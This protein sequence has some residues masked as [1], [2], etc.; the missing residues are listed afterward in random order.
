MDEVGKR[1]GIEARWLGGAGEESVSTR[2]SDLPLP[3]A[4]ARLLGST[5]FLL[6]TSRDGGGRITIFGEGRSQ[7]DLPQTEPLPDLAAPVAPTED[8]SPGPLETL[9]TTALDEPDRTERV[10]ALDQLTSLAGED[11]DAQVALEQLLNFAAD[12]T[13]K[14][15]AREALY[16][17]LERVQ[18]QR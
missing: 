10:R 6:V 18:P 13:V 17:A 12:D 15:A 1:S 11:P 3:E 7:G 8:G 16:A 9:I 4:I 5:S 14:E 2:F